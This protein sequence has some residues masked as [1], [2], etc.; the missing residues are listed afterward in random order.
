MQNR[1]FQQGTNP[2]PSRV[3]C[4]AT[5]TAQTTHGPRSGAEDELLVGGGDESC[6]TSYGLRR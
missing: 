1:P 5:R 2:Q 6:V 4:K 3:S